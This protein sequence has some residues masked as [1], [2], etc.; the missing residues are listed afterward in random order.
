[1][2]QL[3]AVSNFIAHDFAEISRTLDF[4]QIKYNTSLQFFKSFDESLHTILTVY[5]DYNLFIL[6][7]S[8]FF[9]LGILFL[10]K[11][12]TLIMYCINSWPSFTEFWTDFTEY[13]RARSNEG[14]RGA[15][16]RDNQ[17]IAIPLIQRRAR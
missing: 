7:Y 9:I 6:W 8:A 3:T 14:N 1:M 16:V 15:N 13:R 2:S 17:H 4:I 10:I 12:V 5:T 11:V